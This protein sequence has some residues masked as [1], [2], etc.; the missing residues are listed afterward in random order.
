M[1]AK[2]R[3]H[4]CGV[5]VFGHHRQLV[6]AATNLRRESHAGAAVTDCG[7]WRRMSA[8]PRFGVYRRLI[9]G[10]EKCG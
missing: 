6:Y 8:I 3:Q 2:C 9:G 10:G 1:L 5:V 4:R 7:L